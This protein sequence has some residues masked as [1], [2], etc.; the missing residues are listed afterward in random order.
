[1]SRSPGKRSK[2]AGGAG[3]ADALADRQLID[4]C[5]AA[6]RAAWEELYRRFQPGLAAGVRS[7]LG[8]RREDEELVEEIT[9]RVWLSVLDRPDRLLAPFDPSRHV[10]LSTYLTFLARKE[11]QTYWR[12]ER[13]RRW[14]E[15]IAAALRGQGASGSPAEVD[16]AMQEFLALLTP[17]E[18]AFCEA[19]LLPS[20]HGNP[21]EIFSKTNVW[22][23]R[24]RVERKLRDFLKKEHPAQ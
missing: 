21:A 10:R 12:S 23:L 20:S 13:R 17:R 3:H 7:L 1:M 8:R 19:F 14:R 18:R 9:A 22:Q 16:T 5:L 11:L 2:Q 15:D 24:H 6:E 4:R